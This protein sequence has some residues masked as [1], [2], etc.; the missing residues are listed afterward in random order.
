AELERLR[1]PRN[2]LEGAQ[3]EVM[4]AESRPEPFDDPAFLYEL[5]VDGFRA[6]AERSGS[7]PRIYYRRGSDST[8]VY[9]DLGQALLSLPAEHLVLDGEIAVLDDQGRPVFQ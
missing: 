3:V 1:A 2:R 7:R 5:K 4:L 8:S 9:P 6:V